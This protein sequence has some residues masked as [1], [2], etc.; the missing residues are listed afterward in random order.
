MKAQMVLGE[1]IQDLCIFS[2]T[3]KMKGYFFM[4]WNNEILKKHFIKIKYILNI[5]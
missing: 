3:S 4:L 5:F 1:V 2:K